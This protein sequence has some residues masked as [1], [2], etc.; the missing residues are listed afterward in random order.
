MEVSLPAQHEKSKQNLLLFSS[1]IRWGTWPR[2]SGHEVCA[3]RGNVKPDCF[4]LQATIGREE[5]WH[6][7]FPA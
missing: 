7:A 6:F 5:L 1:N 3:G 4:F 2:G